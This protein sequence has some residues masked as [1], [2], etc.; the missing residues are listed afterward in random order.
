[1]NKNDRNRFSNH[2][3]MNQSMNQYSLI[4]SKDSII[5]TLYIKKRNKTDT[6][7]ILYLR[8][9]MDRQRVER[10]I[11]IFL[12]EKEW[13]PENE[14]IIGDDEINFHIKQQKEKIV[15]ELKEAFFIAEQSMSSN[16]DLKIANAIMKGK[17]SIPE[18]IL[19]IFEDELFR[20][21]NNEGDGF[22][23]ANIQKHEVCRNH[24]TEFLKFK[25]N[26]K[27][28]IIGQI[29][30]QFILD[31]LN[32]LRTQKQ[33]QHNT[34]IKH[35][36]V[37]KKMY[38]VALDNRWIDH[39]A[40]VGIK[41]GLKEV[42]RDILTQEELDRMIE[43]NFA[44]NRL[45]QVRDYFVFSCYT[46]LAY[47]DLTNLRRKN[48][49]DYLNRCWINIE[50]T[51]TNISAVI[52]LLTPA[53]LILEHYNP[54]WK[55]T[56]AE[57]LIFKTISNQKLNAYLKE[58]A[59]LCNIEKELTFHLARHTFATTVTL[60]NN[61]PIET[62]SKMLG[63]SRITMTQHYSKVINQKVARDME[64]LI[65]Q[66]ENENTKKQLYEASNK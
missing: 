14:I 1:M 30:K 58:I 38:K 23:D 65:N 7:G 31:F 6:S 9:T 33:C 5:A 44:S 11:G 40:F 63:H 41:L 62:V 16:A 47:I 57:S 15:R 50:R 56:P 48:L 53:R 21:R 45:G 52:P 64:D 19:E 34:S 4:E 42:K 39:N 25:Y 37:F 24:L 17:L 8:C 54:N 3:P 2:Q 46:G 51:K 27:D 61:I 22:S 35:L 26:K 55:N 36:Q 66:L 20:M 10:S 49:S 29:N 12:S 18:T 13:D 43:K 32:F 59:V 60:A 28:I